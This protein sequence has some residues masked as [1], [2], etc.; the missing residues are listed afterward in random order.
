MRRYAFI[1]RHSD[2]QFNFAWKLRMRIRDAIKRQFTEKAK[3]AKELLGCSFDEFVKHFEDKFT[4][5][6]AWGEFMKGKIHI[7]HI[8]P[9]ASFDLTKPE[10]Q[11]KCFHFTNLQPLW[12]ADNIRKGKKLQCA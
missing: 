9:C 8:R 10:Q 4:E 5:G 1:K 11:K 6:M 3:G 2:V 7:D 12:A